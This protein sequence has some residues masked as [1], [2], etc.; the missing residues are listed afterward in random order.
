MMMMISG[1]SF[2]IKLIATNSN[3][4]NNYK[5]SFNLIKYINLNNFKNTDDQLMQRAQLS[6]VTLDQ[7]K[8]GC[9]QNNNFFTFIT[10]YNHDSHDQSTINS[11]DDVLS[12]IIAN[13]ITS[14]F[15]SANYINIYFDNYCY[16]INDTNSIGDMIHLILKSFNETQNDTTKKN[17]KSEYAFKI[18]KEYNYIIN[19]KVVDVIAKTI[20]S[21]LFSYNKL[22]KFNEKSGNFYIINIKFDVVLN[23]DYRHFKR[24]HFN[25]IKKNTIHLSA[26]I[27]YN[28]IVSQLNCQKSS[29]DI[30]KNPTI[31]LMVVIINFKTNDEKLNNIRDDAYNNKCDDFLYLTNNNLSNNNTLKNVIEMENKNKKNFIKNINNHN[32]YNKCNDTQQKINKMPKYIINPNDKY[33]ANNNINN[34]IKTPTNKIDYIIDHN[35]NINLNNKSIDKLKYISQNIETNQNELLK[36]D[37]N[38]YQQMI[39]YP[40]GPATNI[41]WGIHPGSGLKG[42]GEEKNGNQA[43]NWTGGGSNANWT[44][45]QRSNNVDPK[46][47]QS[48]QQCSN[49]SSNSGNVPNLGS[50]S[51]GNISS[52]VRCFSFNIVYFMIKCKMSIFFINL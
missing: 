14:S 7:L 44:N 45:Q 32:S 13:K 20:N 10:F 39:L 38:K 22:I 26:A 52:Q 6:S 28:T 21:F 40:R 18:N 41:G 12:F 37:N 48:S 36:K 30:A 51:S 16:F 1:A 50:S 35:R 3:I 29:N 24:F 31:N 17:L 9:F 23:D 25:L 47:S 19:I 5:I 2:P 4:N 27:H 11:N 34:D 42:G 8:F 49:Q 46:N 43:N 33:N 15:Y